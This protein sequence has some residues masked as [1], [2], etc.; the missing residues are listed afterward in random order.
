MNLIFQFI[1]SSILHVNILLIINI[2]LF[3][4]IISKE[5]AEFVKEIR[6]NYFKIILLS[7]ANYIKLNDTICSYFSNYSSRINYTNSN[8][9]EDDK[10]YLCFVISNKQLLIINNKNEFKNHYDLSFLDGDNFSI[11]PFI[12]QNNNLSFIMTYTNKSNYLNIIKY[13]LND[14]NYKLYLIDSFHYKDENITDTFEN[15]FGCIIS[16]KFNKYLTCC[17]LNNNTLTSLVFDIEDNITFFN[18]N[19]IISNNYSKNYLNNSVSVVSTLSANRKDNMV[20]LCYK[21]G[22]I[23]INCYFYNVTNNSFAFKSEIQRCQDNIKNYYFDETNQ[24]V[25]ICRKEDKEIYEYL[26][27]D[28][29]FY[30]NFSSKLINATNYGCSKVNNLFLFFNTSIVDYDLI[31]NCYNNTYKYLTDREEIIINIDDLLKEEEINYNEIISSYEH[32]DL[33]TVM[34]NLNSILEDKTIGI[35][36]LI[37]GS[38][39]TI[40]ICPTN[41]TN[42]P[43]STQLNL[44]QCE[45]I[46]R[47]EYKLNSSFITIFLLEITNP[48]PQSLLNK[49]EYKIY[50]DNLTELDLNKCQN[51][52]IEIIY[53]IKQIST[54]DYN[55]ISSYKDMGINIFN[56]SDPFFN[57]ICKVF[58]DFENDIILE[59]RIKDIYQNYSVCE[60]GCTYI[61]IDIDFR[62][63]TCECDVKTNISIEIPEIILK[64]SDKNTNNL[65]AFK[66]YN[67]IFSSDDKINNIGFWIFTFVLG[68]HVP[69]WFH[70]INAGIN[71]I[72]DYIIEE[73]K[74]YGYHKKDINGKRKSI[75]K[76]RRNSRRKSMKPKTDKQNDKNNDNENDN[77]NDQNKENDLNNKN[78]NPSVPPLK[79][80]NN[81]INNNIQNGRKRRTINN[82]TGIKNR[83]LQTN[84]NKGKKKRRFRKSCINSNDISDDNDE[85]NNNEIKSTKNRRRRKTLKIKNKTVN[86]SKNSKSNSGDLMKNSFKFNSPNVIVTQDFEFE[87]K[88]NKEEEPDIKEGIN[89]ININLLD[90]KRN[91]TPKESNKI[92]N[93][94][95]YEEA[96]EYDRR[97]FIK[98][99]YIFLLSK[100]TI[101][102]TFIDK[103]P[104]ELIS[105]KICIFIFVIAT[106]LTFNAFFYFNSHISEKY[107]YTKGLFF[108]TF[109]HNMTIILLACLVTFIFT[110]SI[111][112][113]SN[114]NYK[115]REIFKKEED[116]L[117]S[118]N[119]YIVTQERKE[120]ILKEIDEILNKLKKKYLALFLIEFIVMLFYWYYATGFGHVYTNTQ[121]SWIFNSFISIIMSFIFDCFLC[122]VFSEL[123]KISIDNK[124]KG[125]Y[126][127]VMFI[128]NFG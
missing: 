82:M 83:I 128:Y 47:D 33:E 29:D 2:I 41:A 93:N 53:S 43:S 107:N 9:Q 119:T 50:D 85:E 15:S 120:E 69:L 68:G 34:S 113:L 79:K 19:S 91:I 5:E 123:Y 78:N 10:Y 121:T 66:C 57:D 12:N 7:S 100:Q 35:Y 63:V 39:F 1:K 98:I 61:D 22:N 115:I 26:L 103:S 124:I 67:L 49:V 87:I 72:Y 16:D 58:P 122:V 48:N 108:F 25:L 3:A 102:H 96:I 62:T 74:E 54:L 56:L 21:Q 45:S 42:R 13:N 77:G 23:D 59:D 97:P 36:Y 101:F 84:K 8:M 92:L 104:M 38:N 125:L 37:R 94:Y 44:T 118:D 32:R 116:K 109:T 89:L 52:K 31:N 30:S 46:L 126:K 127:F 51:S 90:E 73:M 117:K 65:D 17:F 40:T 14:S 11:N 81:N 95:T 20:F 24:Y 88:N 71:V 110:V 28:T 70:Y 112:Q 99:L 75:L 18:Y 76:K 111:R 105:I 80:N 55:Q 106:C 4:F 86:L 6:I 27:N 64:K 114:S 60:E